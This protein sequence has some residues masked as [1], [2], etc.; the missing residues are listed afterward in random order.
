MKAAISSTCA[1]ALTG[2]P[3]GCGMTACGTGTVRRALAHVEQLCTARHHP[4]ERAV[5]AG[6]CHHA[7]RYLSIRY[8]CAGVQLVSV[9]EMYPDSLRGYSPVVRGI[10][11]SNAEVIIRQ[12]GV[13]IDQRY[14]PPGAFEISDLYAVSGS[15][16]PD[17]TIKE[18][19]GT[20]QRL[21]VPFA[22]L[23]VLQR[24]RAAQLRP[25]RR[26]IPCAGRERR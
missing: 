24:E 11:K 5:D 4:A 19:D 17:V 20:E 7:G 15:G 23:P 2:A 26:A 9:E 10:A 6:R 16:D 13:V 3:G 22:S 14:V 1:T 8:R 18:S 12:N 21:L 25:G